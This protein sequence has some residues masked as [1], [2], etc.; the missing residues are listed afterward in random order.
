[1]LLLTYAET[2]PYD[3]ALDLRIDADGAFEAVGGSYVSHRH[4]RRLD[5]RDL[6]A[7]TS[8]LAALTSDD[9]RDETTG[10]VPRDFARVLRWTGGVRRWHGPPPTDAALARVLARLRDLSAR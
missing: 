6:A 7:L 8:D 5:A 2:G 10:A 1:M 4:S 3:S 9:A